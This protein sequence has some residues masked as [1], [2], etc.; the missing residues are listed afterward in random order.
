MTD[1]TIP[2]AVDHT[3]IV[4]PGHEELDHVVAHEGRIT[5]IEN[6]LQQQRQEV[7]EA[8]DRTRSELTSAIDSARQEQASLL[9][10][11]LARLE[12]I[13][14]TLEQQIQ[15]VPD[16]EVPPIE[17]LPLVPEI[18]STTKVTIPKGAR[19]RRLARSSE[20]RGKKE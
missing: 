11:K 6:A 3:T 4:Q 14:S 8:I 13:S 1:I 2:D 16:E 10:G 12:E 20:R 9:E 17:A 18:E 5:N 7:F 19:Q 15:K